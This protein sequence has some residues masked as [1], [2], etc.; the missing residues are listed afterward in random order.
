MPQEDMSPLA[1]E[2]KDGLRM[3]WGVW[4]SSRIEVTRIVVPV[5][6][7][8]TP[9]KRIETM[10]APLE[11]DP[12]RCNGC[13]GVLNPHCSVDFR[14]KVWTCPFCMT[15]NHFPPHYA[16]NISEQNLPVELFSQYTTV[17]YELQVPPAGP[18][19]FLLVVDT[20]LEDAELE[21]L[22]D[23]LQQ[24]LQLLPETALVGLITFGTHVM[25]HELDSPDC[26]RSYVFRG[27]KEYTPQRVQDLLNIAPPLHAQAPGMM[28]Q[29]GMAADSMG[30]RTPALGRFLC[31]VGDCSFNLEKILED[32]QRDSWPVPS[33]Q[34]PQRCTGVALSVATGLLESSF[35][36]QGARVMLFVGGP[37]TVGP[38]MIVGRP[39]TEDIRSHTD[40]AKGTAPHYKGAVKHY[41][42]LAE[43]AVSASHVIDIFACSL[44][45]V[46]MMEMKVCVEKTGGLMVLAD[47]FSQ[48]VFKE[49]LLRVLKKL[50]AEVPKDGGHLQ[51]GFAASLEVLTSRE[52]KVAGAIGPC[53][54]LR[55]MAPNVAETAIGEGGTNAWSMGGIDP[56]V[57]VA[58]YFEVTNAANNPLPPSKRRFIQFITQYQH[59]SGRF[60]LRATTYSG[61]WH[62]DAADMGPVSRSFDQEAACVLMTRIAVQR[63]ESD[64]EGT[65]HDVLRW[66]DRS[67]IKLSSKF[68]SYRKD[69]PA[70]FAFPQEFVLYPQFMFHLRRSQFLQL[71]N[72][73]P[74][75]SSYYRTILIRENVANSL[76]MIQPSLLSYSFSAPPQPVMLDAT[77]I[78]PD[79][80]LLL[81]TFFHVVVF[82][83][84]TV[85]AWRA[86][87]YQNTEEHINFKNLLDSPQLDAQMTMTSRFPVPR[88]IVCDQ[89]KSQAR[90]LMA[91]LNPSIT[92]HTGEVGMGQAMLTDDVSLR[93]FMEH[94]MKLAVQTP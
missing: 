8:Y 17:E 3:S 26:A 78:R 72:S 16:E 11:Y 82:H 92:H 48:S 40:L 91:K 20:C 35:P 71:F 51:M 41:A 67:L 18:P 32:L 23:S 90:F 42:S 59:A 2:E 24:V 89:H 4:P 21:H 49:S 36:R 73:S 33:D 1:L 25:V 69:D 55:K 94:L 81:D 65:V 93:V 15:R 54:S 80:I 61:A 88:F 57:T 10:P 13:G 45:Q 86:A 37:P 47:T 44:D 38:G 5:A 50:P 52:F 34:R 39:K 83:G 74:D 87:G 79:C 77:S 75:E 22:K 46:G 66:V 85:A 58:V 7:L 56:A 70:S 28:M 63:T 43:R 60:R 29:P 62:N 14:T 12:I 84:E 53:S 31:P 19:V 64:E 9:L 30:G 76:V 27:S 6:G 68:G